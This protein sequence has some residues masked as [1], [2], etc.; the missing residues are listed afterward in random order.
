MA[1]DTLTAGEGETINDAYGEHFVRGHL[2]E[3]SITHAF[4]NGLG[5]GVWDGVTALYYRTEPVLPANFRFYP[6]S[7]SSGLTDPVQGIDPAFPNSQ[8][9][10]GTANIVYIPPEGITETDPAELQGRYRCRQIA[11]YDMEGNHIGV[12]YSSN[13]ARIAVHQMIVE[14]DISATRIDWA[15]W[16]GWRVYCDTAIEWNDGKT[17]RNIKRFETHIAYTGPTTL[18]ETLN[19]FT[20]MTASYWQDDGQF[21][22]FFPVISRAPVAT[23]D[24]TNISKG[25]FEHSLIDIR[26]QPTYITINFRD[27]DSDYLAPAVWTH[28]NLEGIAQRGVIQAPGSFQFGAMYYSQAQRLAKY[29]LRRAA[30]YPQ[31]LTLETTGGE[32]AVLPGDLVTVAHPAL[33]TV[34]VWHVMET[35]DQA[36]GADS[37]RFVLGGPWEAGY[38]DQDHEPIPATLP[39]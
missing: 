37:R 22:R 1:I 32:I 14:A 35:E 34:G 8:T 23:F 29:W 17:V 30:D 16:Y 9:F 19:M 39:E 12:G 2:L 13:P 15:S 28:K 21:Y 26:N 4:R 24:E 25:T 36:T 27:L 33:N 38:S 5:R 3:K 18:P 10:S 7:Q 31:R 11:D 20:D 6:G